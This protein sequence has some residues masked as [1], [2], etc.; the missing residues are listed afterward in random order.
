MSTMISALEKASRVAFA[1][2][3]CASINGVVQFNEVHD[4]GSASATNSAI[5]TFAVGSAATTINITVQGNLVYN[6]FGNDA[7][8]IGAKGGQDRL[9]GGGSV[10]GNVVHDTAQ[11]GI[12][13]DASNTLAQTGS[14]RARRK[15][16][17]IMAI[18]LSE[19]MTLSPV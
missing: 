18:S 11:D 7:I 9:L 14:R 8:K 12:T 2:V 6:H 3:A 5:Y 4:L 1:L 15:P 17:L 16:R 19:L 13:I 10:V